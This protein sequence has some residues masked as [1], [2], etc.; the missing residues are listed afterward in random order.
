MENI[1][2]AVIDDMHTKLSDMLDLDGAN[3]FG[4]DL[5]GSDLHHELC[6]T[7]YFI[8]GRQKA[9][10]F[11]GD[12]AFQAMHIIKEYEQSNFGEMTTDISE[13]EKVVNMLAYIIGEQVLS[14][15]DHLSDNCWDRGL[16]VEDL[17][18][19]QNQISLIDPVTI[20]E[21]A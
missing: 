21:A 6:N 19:I 7:H 13:P 17:Q 12:N 15:S 3:N 11:I 14:Y 8:I 20:K 16:T 10:D 18:K 2:K 4:Y 9:I 5:D 1:I